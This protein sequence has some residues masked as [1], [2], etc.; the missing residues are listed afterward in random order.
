MSEL[1]APA[2]VDVWWSAA[3][4]SV[5]LGVA[6]IVYALWRRSRGQPREK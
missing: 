1:A 3:L 4:L 6:G 2:L 5:P